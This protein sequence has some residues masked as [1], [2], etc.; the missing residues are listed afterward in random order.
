EVQGLSLALCWAT[1][2]A[3]PKKA[4]SLRLAALKLP[5]PSMNQVRRL[6]RRWSYSTRPCPVVGKSH[7]GVPRASGIPLGEGGV[8]AP[9][10]KCQCRAVPEAGARRGFTLIHNDWRK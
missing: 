3:R 4:A 1:H 9:S 5:E 2:A 8:E 10:A 6:M 7:I